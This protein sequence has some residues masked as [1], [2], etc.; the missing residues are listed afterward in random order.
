MLAKKKLHDLKVENYVL[1]GG[2]TED[3]SPGYSLRAFKDCSREV[4]EEP[5]YRGV[6]A[7]KKSHAVEYQK[8][9]S[10]V[11]RWSSG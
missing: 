10:A 9:T 1:F 5:R 4:R 3:S 11:P 2:I 6:F 7:E 8:F